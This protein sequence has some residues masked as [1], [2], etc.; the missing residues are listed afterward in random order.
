MFTKTLE[1]AIIILDDGS[2]LTGLLKGAKKTSLG[3]LVFNT[4][5]TGYLETFT[6]PSFFGQ[7]VVPT[8]PL[9][10]NYGVCKNDMESSKAWVKG[11]II[12][13]ICNH[14]SNFRNELTLTDWLEKN[15]IIAV[16]GIDTRTLTK[17]IRNGQV[18]NCAIIP[19]K[20][21]KLQKNL[22]ESLL[23][24]LKNEN[25]KTTQQAV[26]CT[27]TKSI[28][29]FTKADFDYTTS[30]LILNK[31]KTQKNNF[32]ICILDFGTKINIIKNLV[33]RCKEAILLPHNTPPEKIKQLKP[34]GIVLT[35]GPGNPA[36]N[37]EIIQNLQQL[38]SFKIPIF[39]ICLGHQL[40]ALANG[41]RTEKLKF[42]H[43]GANQPVI[44]K[45]T[46]RMFI[47][48]QNHGYVVKNDTINKQIANISF[49]N[50]NDNT[51]E[52][53]EFNH[54]PAFSVQFHPESCGGPNDTN[55][56]FDEFFNLIKKTKILKNK[57]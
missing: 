49:S 32:K 37:K 48:A 34:D 53:L 5:M 36:D 14:P 45:K 41:A 26:E 12:N 18:K 46:N 11:L 15:D 40:L 44:E 8:F 21:L 1:K 51:C 27:S 39:G 54:F 22:K 43:R 33:W 50:L 42:G 24:S 31:T 13:Q 52:G 56:L 28:K 35:N 2:T 3:E 38:Q 7:I 30:N 57:R 23:N 20:T 29:K 17:K 9:I 16:S 19:E 25:L 47:T 6:D 10:G 4:S 55:F